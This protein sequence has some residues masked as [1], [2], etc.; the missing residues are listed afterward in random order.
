MKNKI[1]LTTILCFALAQNNFAQWTATTGPSQP[2]VVSVATASANTFASAGSAVSITTN[3]GTNWTLVSNGLVGTIHAVATKGTDV[4]AGAGGGAVFQS[5]NNGTNWTNTSTGL[6]AYDI[7][8]LTVNGNDIYAGTFGVYRSTNNGL[9]WTKL[10]QTWNASVVSVAV[11]GNTILAATVNSGCYI[12]T[13]N[14]ANWNTINT[15]LPSSLNA[16][17]IVGTTF[18]A[19]ANSGLYISTNNGASWT[20]TSVTDGIGSFTSVG[21]N[22]FAG[23]SS[24]GGVFLSTNSGGSWTAINN[25][26][27]NLTVYSLATNSTYVF[28]GTTG[29]VWKR[30]LSEVLPVTYTI[31]TSSNPSNAGTTTGGGSYS[32][33]NSVT[34]SATPNNG[35]VFNNWTESGN[36]VSAN[37]TYTFTAS[38]NRNLVAEFSPTTSI[39]DLTTEN[40]VSIYPN[41]SNGSF[42]LNSDKVSNIKIFNSIGQLTLTKENVSGL[43]EL[44]INESGTYLIVVQERNSN[45]ISKTQIIIQ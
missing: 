41:P 13:D 36:I 33:G 35:F 25:G 9:L 23:S 14:G 17:A 8:S 38:A 20:L 28:A 32:S 24:G 37:S 44:S 1:L 2:N 34:V 3:N 39:K 7:R 45:K 27:T 40:F 21:T 4:F 29:Y 5:S 19:G 12:S 11:S 6:P 15:G 43:T 16:V 42:T 26:L 30:P 31:A 10:N 18:L 22:V